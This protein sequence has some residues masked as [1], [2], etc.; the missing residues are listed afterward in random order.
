VVGHRALLDGRVRD[1]LQK[2]SD[3]IHDDGSL[4]WLKNSV[5]QAF[6]RSDPNVAFLK[7]DSENVIVGRRGQDVH[8]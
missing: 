7:V 5:A 2:F 1:I 8:I 3:L 4:F 6:G